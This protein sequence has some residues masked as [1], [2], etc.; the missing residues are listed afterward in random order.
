MLHPWKLACT[1]LIA[2]LM[3]AASS[4]GASAGLVLKSDRSATLGLS[5]EVP[6]AIE[7]RIRAF[8]SS[9]GSAASS[10]VPLF[11]AG[12]VTKAISTRGM[13]VL[14][15]KVPTIRSYIG[16]YAIKDIA[17]VLSSDTD[18]AKI[19][20][21]A[22]GE[23]WASLRLR[24]DRD[25]AAVLTRLFPG[26]DQDLLEALQPP[27][28]YDNPVS[29]QEYRS[30]L[31]GLLG[32]TAAGSLDGLVFKLVLDLPGAVTESVAGAL[33]DPSGRRVTLVIPAL[34][35]MVLEKPVDFRV[36]WKE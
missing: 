22:S 28:L 32:K 17:A 2:T 35:A 34:D 9:S 26:I 29:T 12:A 25:N 24:I 20:V 36:K 3:Y 18:L 14:E 33:V 23:G 31:A 5:V 10:A 11:D 1:V 8:A 15:S 21:Y 30:M 13:V 16:A 4:C 19:L 6:A 27:A 7:T